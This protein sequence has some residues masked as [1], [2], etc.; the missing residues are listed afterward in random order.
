VTTYQG[1]AQEGRSKVAEG[2]EEHRQTSDSA[3]V[4][5]LALV[6][7]LSRAAGMN[8]CHLAYEANAH[9]FFLARLKSRVLCTPQAKSSRAHVHL[10]S[11]APSLT[12]RESSACLCAALPAA[13]ATA[14]V[15]VR[16]EVA[17]EGLVGGEAWG[18]GAA[19]R[20][21][22]LVRERLGL[23]CKFRAPA[24]WAARARGE[25]YAAACCAASTRGAGAKCVRRRFTVCGAQA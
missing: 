7:L 15:A 13:L 18:T 4:V 6:L 2:E 17:C 23:T 19:W 21:N 14:A 11:A 10:I 9:A 24:F 20:A 12:S 1:T 3:Q 22:C 25:F 8:I 5:R 16:L